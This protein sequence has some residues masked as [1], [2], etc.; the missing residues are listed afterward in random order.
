MKFEA[1]SKIARWR[2][3]IDFEDYPY[4]NI[5]DVIDVKTEGDLMTLLDRLYGDAVFRRPGEADAGFRDRL[6]E[7]FVEED[8]HEGQVY[9]EYTGQWVWL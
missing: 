6:R 1:D 5:K 9:N 3:L 7:K 2:Y 4:D 8:L